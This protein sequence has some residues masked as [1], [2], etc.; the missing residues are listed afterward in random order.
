ML[1]AKKEIAGADPKGYTARLFLPAA[2]LR[3]RDFLVS[4]RQLES[5]VD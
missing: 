3:E 1:L 4:H 5:R 2:F